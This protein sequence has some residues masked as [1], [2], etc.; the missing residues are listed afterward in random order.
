AGGR[1]V[2]LSAP[3]RI[4]R[5]A[6]PTKPVDTAG[7]R[8][9][10]IGACEEAAERRLFHERYIYPPLRNQTPLDAFWKTYTHERALCS[11][12]LPWLISQAV[13]RAIPRRFTSRL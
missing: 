1:R 11:K 2:T 6:T 4:L 5:L 9:P 7:S 8:P 10:D 12:E 13:R 3:L